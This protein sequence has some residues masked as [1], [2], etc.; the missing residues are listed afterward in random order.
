[1]SV[2]ISQADLIIITLMQDSGS[3]HQTNTSLEFKLG[4]NI[5]DNLRCLYDHL[6]TPE[7]VDKVKSIGSQ[8][9]TE[10]LGA[11]LTRYV[12]M[13]QG[14]F[15]VGEAHEHNEILLTKDITQLKDDLKAWTIQV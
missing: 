6:N 3:S 9:L 7:D 8:Q 10:N 1:M 15:E 5:F 2:D 13:T 14:L 12:V 4:S 11:Y